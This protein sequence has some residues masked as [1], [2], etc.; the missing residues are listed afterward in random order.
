MMLWKAT[1]QQGPPELNHNN[2]GWS[3]K[4][5]VLFPVFNTSS[6][7]P[8]SLMDVLNCKCKAEGKACGTSAC[9]CHKNMHMY[10]MYI[11]LQV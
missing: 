8:A 2:Y 3:M 11:I 6:P 7:A 9:T 1:N 4:D 10:I 5:G